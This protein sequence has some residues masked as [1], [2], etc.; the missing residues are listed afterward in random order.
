MITDEVGQ[1]IEALKREFGGDITQTETGDGGA[2]VRI[3]TIKLGAPYAQDESWFAFTLTYLH[4]YGDIYPIFVRPD[5]SRLDGRPLVSP[6]HIN[7]AFQGQPAVMVSR[8]TKLFGP[9]HPVGP[10]LKLLKVRQ[11]MLSQ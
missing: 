7:N 1:A 2:H 5:L 3:P 10:V 4:P 9:G 8:R 6:I 11:W